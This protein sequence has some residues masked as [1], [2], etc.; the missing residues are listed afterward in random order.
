MFI[1]CGYYQSYEN[2]PS[3]KIIGIYETL[4]EAIDIQENNMDV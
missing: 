2:L 4:D 1:L 3:V